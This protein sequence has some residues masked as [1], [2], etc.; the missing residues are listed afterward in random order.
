MIHI[1]GASLAGGEGGGQILRSALTL[2][3]LTGRPLHITNIRARRPKP[4][5]QAQH[6]AAARAA[7]T[8]SQADMAG[9][10]IGSADLHF[11]PGRVQP[12]AYHFDIGTAGAAT[13]VLQTL[14]L[15][16]A[17]AGASSTLTI[18][19]GTHVPWSPSFH[20]LDRVWLPALRRLGYDA[21][22]QLDRAGFYPRGGGQITAAI[23]PAG[24]L[25]PLDLRERGQL[26]R[27]SGLSIVANLPESIAARQAAQA[28]KRL[29]D[30]F[31]SFR[32]ETGLLPSPGQGTALFLRAESEHSLAGFGALG[33]RGKP[34]E[35]VA[36]EA[37]DDLQTYLSTNAALDPHLADQILLPLAFAPG[38]SRFQTAAI[39]PHLL[40]NAEV[41]QA[42]L[43]LNIIIEG[44]TG[45]PGWVIIEP[46][47]EIDTNSGPAVEST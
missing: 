29:R 25:L 11:R 42:F 7:A 19:G 27:L 35:R 30:R 20:Y 45:E 47:R 3:L 43:P 33:A 23:S 4:G 38:P 14:F 39:T 10:A 26:R 9:A 15:P 24:R 34:A 13:L 18:T 32:V 21:R 1:D 8:I 17:L 46:P 12:G 41:I 16:L 22:F 2:S 40:T 36:D 31:P 28:E 44:R 5:L 37:V 6:L